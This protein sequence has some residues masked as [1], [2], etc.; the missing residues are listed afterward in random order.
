MNIE[1]ALEYCKEH[2]LTVT[3]DLDVNHFENGNRVPQHKVKVSPNAWT[4]FNGS[5]FLEAVEKCKKDYE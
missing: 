1:E 4:E 2:C 3:F 5:T